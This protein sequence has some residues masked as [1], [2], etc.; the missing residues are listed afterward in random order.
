[1][2]EYALLIM[3]AL[4][5]KHFF[6][7]YVLQTEWMLRQKHSL[8]RPGGYAHS[9]IHTAGSVLVFLVLAVPAGVIVLLAAVE[10]VVH[11][12]IDFAKAQLDGGIS[13][14]ERPRAFWALNGFDQLLHRATYLTLTYLL[15]RLT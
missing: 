3:L 15:L 11:L 13:S 6:G 5:G 8:A 9:A 14:D 4:E 12:L 1:M 2:A 10:F 7:D